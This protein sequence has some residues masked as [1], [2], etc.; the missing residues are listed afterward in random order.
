MCL[1]RYNCLAQGLI[2][3]IHQFGINFRENYLA[4]HY[5]KIRPNGCKL[6]N[7]PNKRRNLRSKFGLN[8]KTVTSR[9]VMFH[10][11]FCETLC[12]GFSWGAWICTLR[13]VL[14]CEFEPWWWQTLFRT[15]AQHLCFL[16]DSISFIWFDTVICLS[17]LSCELWNKKWKKFI[18]KR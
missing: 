18:L 13:H 3:A 15:Q 5:K 14:G 7:F 1:F 6:H 16:H 10:G 2:G 8:K 12:E 4:S 11:L 9:H 17:N